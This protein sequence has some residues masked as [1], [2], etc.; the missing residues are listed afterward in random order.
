MKKIIDLIATGSG[1]DPEQLERAITLIEDLGFIPRASITIFGEHPLYSNTDQQRLE[2]LTDAL[3]AE[4]SDIIWCLGGGS[5]TIRLLPHLYDL[6]PPTKHKMIIGLSDVTALLIFLSQKWGWQ[7]VHAPPAGY[8]ALNKL[9]PEALEAIVQL[10]QGRTKALCYGDLLPLNSTAQKDQVIEG[11][12]TG[13]NMS[14]IE[15]SL[16]TP[17]QIET[18]NRILFFEDTNEE[19]Y[20]IAERLEHLRQAGIFKNVKAI[21]F[22]GFSHTEKEKNKPD[23]VDF[24]LKD[25]AENI[26]IPCFS[27]LPVGHKDYCRPLIINLK[28]TLTTGHTG[29]LVQQFPGK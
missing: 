21:L 27:N 6:T 26:E 10:I 3:Y 8:P 9:T 7:V 11:L 25:F 16:G 17:W 2:N 23:L 14:L 1:K 5:G 28:A 18:Q 12:L 13:G 24:V 4:D 20:R 19:A 22:G 29:K 15:Y